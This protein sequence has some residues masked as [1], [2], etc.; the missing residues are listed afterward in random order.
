MLHRE[1]WVRKKV[2]E[3]KDSTER[4]QPMAGTAAGLV[5]QKIGAVTRWQR[6]SVS[7][8]AVG[9]GLML[10][11][12]MG[13]LSQ[14]IQSLIV[15]PHLLPTPSQRPQPGE[16]HMLC[17]DIANY[18]RVCRMCCEGGAGHRGSR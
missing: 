8:G 4:H 7:L 17:A 13:Y 16:L 11:K 6:N 5:Q 14:N 12:P 18:K 1:R 3:I 10:H 9:A 2:S 15:I